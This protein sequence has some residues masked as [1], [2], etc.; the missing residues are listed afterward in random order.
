MNFVNVGFGNLVSAERI[1]SVAS[2]DAAPIKRL[3]QE[4]KEEGRAIDVTAGRRCRS[5]I[6]C[7]STHVILCALTA[8]ELALRLEGKKV[9]SE[10]DDL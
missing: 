1:V 7:D 10:D 5:V 2:P 8:G 9:G 6:I 3:A 4:A